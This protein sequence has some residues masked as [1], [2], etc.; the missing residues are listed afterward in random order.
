MPILPPSVCTRILFVPGLRGHVSDHWQTLVA[1][2]L[3]GSRTVPS[4]GQDPLSR[5]ARVRN[6]H[7]EIQRDKDSLFLVAHSAGVLIVAHWAAAHP[8]LAAKRIAGALL[9][10]PADIESPLPAGYP[11]LDELTANGWLPVPRARLPF[12][13]IVAGS[14][15]D[16]LARLDRVR[17]LARDWGSAFRSLGAVGHLNPAA[18][19]GPWPGCI[20]IIA[21]LAR[22]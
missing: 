12:P 1:Q 4:E 20:D 3:T 5:E 19:F 14:E 22:I 13:A 6:L 10:T 18:G 9:A 15:N 8:E 21:S 7:R 11:T 16:P 17:E 2:D